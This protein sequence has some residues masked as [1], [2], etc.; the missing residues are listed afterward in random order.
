MQHDKTPMRIASCAGKLTY[1]PT[2]ARRVAKK[3]TR[4][5]KSVGAYH[6]QFCGEWHV[7]RPYLKGAPK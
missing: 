5:G 3:M 6:C 2:L 4:R 7:G 1:G